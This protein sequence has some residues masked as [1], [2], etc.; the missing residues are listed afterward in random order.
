MTK[1][2]PTGIVGA[3]VIEMDVQRDARG[4]FLRVWCRDLFR[5]L[6]LDSDLAQ[7]SLSFNQHAGTVRGLH[8][9]RAPYEETKLVTCA[10]GSL[11]DVA[12]D[13]R[14]NSQ[15]YGRWA[16]VTLTAG[17]G[18]SFYIP[19]GCLHGFQTLEPCTIVAYHIST[20]YASEA[21]FGLRWSDPRLAIPWPLSPSHISEADRNWPT[22]DSRDG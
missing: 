22:L 19:K 12:V 9:Q 21:G 4:S 6:G 10:A 18:R 3:F 14:K 5:D 2:T 16:A 17:D 13:L 11:F 8:G 7:T 1:K 20:P 15:S